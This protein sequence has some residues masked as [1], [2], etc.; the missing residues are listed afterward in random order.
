MSP[1]FRDFNINQYKYNIELNILSIS[2]P[3]DKAVPIKYSVCKR[4]ELFKKTCNPLGSQCNIHT[5]IY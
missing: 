3:V 1:N 2:E 4:R 5:Y